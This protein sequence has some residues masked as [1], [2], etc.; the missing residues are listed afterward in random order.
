MSVS[1]SWVCGG[2][3]GKPGGI[4]LSAR[5]N[6]PPVSSPVALM[7]ISVAPASRRSPSPGSW[8]TAQMP[9]SVARPAWTADHAAETTRPLLRFPA[10]DEARSITAAAAADGLYEQLSNVFVEVIRMEFAVVAVNR[11]EVALRR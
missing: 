4:V 5:K 9:G 3:P 1:V 11:L 2:G 10:S 8:K 6:V 7:T